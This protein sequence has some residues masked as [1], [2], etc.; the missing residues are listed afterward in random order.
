MNAAIKIAYRKFM[1]VAET[2]T[3]HGRADASEVTGFLV[4]A[5]GVLLGVGLDPSETIEEAAEKLKELMIEVA[6]NER[7]TGETIKLRAERMS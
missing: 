1:K 3:L 6:N 5:I 2:E 4:E 7:R